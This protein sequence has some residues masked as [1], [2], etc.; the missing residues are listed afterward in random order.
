MNQLH[1]FYPEDLA[2]LDKL[3]SGVRAVVPMREIA[4]GNRDF[5]VIGVRH[6]VDDNNNALDTALKMAQW[7]SERGYRSTYF[8]LHSA[9]YWELDTIRKAAWTIETL[10]HEVGIHVNALAEAIRGKGDPSTI[11]ADALV[12]LRSSG[13]EV[14]GSAGHGDEMC[15]RFTFVNDELFTECARPG[16]G[17]PDR[18]IGPTREHPLYTPVKIERRSRYDFGLEYDSAWLPRRFYA[19]D[20]GGRWN[21]MWDEIEREGLGDEGQLHMLIHPDWWGH[22]FA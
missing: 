9:S 4:A 12:Q 21:K 7:E 22:A 14:I 20:S 2:D 11:L 19:S 3:F 15:A 16:Y 10:G 5:D 8:L 13:V 18:W 17:E 6:D 1:P